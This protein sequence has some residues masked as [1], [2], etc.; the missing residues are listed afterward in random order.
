MKNIIVVLLL[1]FAASNYA[2]DYKFGKVSKEELEES[3]HPLDSTA[4][5]AYLYSKRRTYYRF[6]KNEGFQIINEIHE[7]IKIYNK[8]GLTKQRNPYGSINQRKE[9][10]RELR[11]LQ[12]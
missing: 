12:Q 4:E 3:V 1:F 9:T 5:A 6:S 11:G 7:R 2:Q 10:K 8:D